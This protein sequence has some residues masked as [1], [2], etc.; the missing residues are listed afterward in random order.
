MYHNL[1]DGLI[2][3]VRINA[4]KSPGTPL[5]III[6]QTLLATNRVPTDTVIESI[7]K[8]IIKG[9]KNEHR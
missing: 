2:N 3:D 7:F 4:T 1:R 6:R 5:R 8:E 9:A